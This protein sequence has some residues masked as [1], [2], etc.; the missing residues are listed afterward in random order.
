MNGFTIIQED[1]SAK[2]VLLD[3]STNNQ[4]HAWTKCNACEKRILEKKVC[5]SCN[6][7]TYCSKEC[8]VK[9]WPEHKK[10]CKSFK[11]SSEPRV[12]IREEVKIGISKEVSDLVSNLFKQ[13]SDID[14]IRFIRL[15]AEKKENVVLFYSILHS[16]LF[17]EPIYISPGSKDYENLRVLIKLDSLIEGVKKRFPDQKVGVIMTVFENQQ[18]YVSIVRDN[19]DIR[20]YLSKYL[21]L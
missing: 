20:M 12:K 14:K 15:C 16:K 19:D 9:D 17:T 7:A 5:G 10:E 3:K 8:Q 6:I 1:L 18:H 13:T 11:I 4:S 2:R 21:L